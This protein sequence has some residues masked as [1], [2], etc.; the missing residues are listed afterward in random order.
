MPK[1]LIP[2]PL[3][4]ENNTSTSF[5]KVNKSSELNEIEETNLNKMN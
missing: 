4:I 3:K 1:P 2:S 5:H